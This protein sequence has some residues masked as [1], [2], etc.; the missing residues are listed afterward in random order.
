MFTKLPVLCLSLAL[1]NV[2]LLLAVEPVASAETRSVP[3][4]NTEGLKVSGWN[5]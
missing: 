3:V 2:G 1:L 4:N 5:L